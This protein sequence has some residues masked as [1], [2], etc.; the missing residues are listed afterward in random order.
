[1]RNPA[2]SILAMLFLLQCGCDDKGFEAY[3][4]DTASDYSGGGGSGASSCLPF[5]AFCVVFVDVLSSPFYVPDFYVPDF[6]VPDFYVPEEV[7]PSDGSASAATLD[8]EVDL[9]GGAFV[10]PTEWACCPADPGVE[11]VWSNDTTGESGT[12]LSSVAGQDLGDARMWAHRWGARVPLAPGVNRITVTAFDRSGH[13]AR[14]S[15]R[16]KRTR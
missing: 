16:V 4:R 6:Y 7:A 3:H 15:I 11:V 10:S 13:V 9:S 5:D 12:A 8:S 1:M 2:V 14:K